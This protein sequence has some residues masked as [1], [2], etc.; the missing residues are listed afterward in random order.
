[1][2]RYMHLSLGACERPDGGPHGRPY[3]GPYAR[4]FERR[5]G[6]QIGNQRVEP[7]DFAH[8]SENP[9]VLQ[10]KSSARFDVHAS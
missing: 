6:G 2:D 1:M 9:P 4:P 10:M 3:G 5:L 8:W 7:V